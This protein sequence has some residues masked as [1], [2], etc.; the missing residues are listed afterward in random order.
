MMEA[1]HNQVYRDKHVNID[2]G[3]FSYLLCKLLEICNL[4][5]VYSI[6]NISS[7]SVNQNT[8]NSIP[9]ATKL[10][11]IQ[12]LVIITCTIILHINTK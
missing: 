11:T 7:Y 5:K 8:V 4:T 10:Y 12:Y 2:C 1:K 6:Q 9:S 3:G